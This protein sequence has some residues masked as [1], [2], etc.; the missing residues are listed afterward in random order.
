M[1][2]LLAILILVLAIVSCKTTEANYRAAYEKAM[3]GRDSLTAIDQTIYGA[4]RRSMGS[5]EITVGNDTVEVKI[6]KVSITEG[7]GGIREWLRT[8]S[9]V[10]GQFKQVFNAKSLRERLV[11]SGHS[12]AFVVETGEPYYFVIL[13]SHNSAEEAVKALKSIPKDFPAAMKEPLPFILKQ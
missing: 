12:G 3:A 4:H 10:V 8:Y 7:G 1:K 6:Q 11:D 2:S 13:S 5:K 9:V